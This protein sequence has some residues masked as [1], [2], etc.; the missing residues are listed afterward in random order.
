MIFSE[1]EACKVARLVFL[2]D[3][4]KVRGRS[5]LRRTLRRMFRKVND[6]GQRTGIPRLLSGCSLWR[7]PQPD[8]HSVRFP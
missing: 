3:R 6:P 1:W 2:A 7:L 4:H 8:D 5:S